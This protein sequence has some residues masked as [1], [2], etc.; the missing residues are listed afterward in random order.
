MPGDDLVF[1]GHMA[2]TAERAVAKLSGKSR[3]DFDDDENLRLALAHLLQI[4][5]EAASRVSPQFRA[6]Q[7][8]VPWRSIIGMRH[9]V[10]HDYLG[11][12]YD[13]VWDTVADELPPLI[14]SLRRSLAS[15]DSN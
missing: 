11:L 6:N 8:A 12:D 13:I 9:K 5:G 10:V 4:V 3:S 15:Q 1:V 7:T 2:E 14:E